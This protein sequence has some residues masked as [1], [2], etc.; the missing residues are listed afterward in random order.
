MTNVPSGLIV[1]E[2]PSA[3]TP[4]EL[5][6]LPVRPRWICRRKSWS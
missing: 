6:Q 1:P 2:A 3:V 4:D 5:T